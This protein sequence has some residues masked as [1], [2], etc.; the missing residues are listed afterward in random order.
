[1]QL[2]TQIR[3]IFNEIVDRKT[4]TKRFTSPTQKC[5]NTPAI[6]KNE[7]V[8]IS[9]RHENLSLTPTTPLNISSRRKQ[10]AV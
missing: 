9:Q 8:L 4:L 5:T 10:R 6:Y 1:M 3:V 7:R 2:N